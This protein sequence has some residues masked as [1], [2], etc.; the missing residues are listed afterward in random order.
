M[1][2]LCPSWCRSTIGR[3]FFFPT[4]NK[5]EI[6]WTNIYSKI[7]LIHTLN[8]RAYFPF[9]YLSAMWVHRRS[10]SLAVQSHRICVYFQREKSQCLTEQINDTKQTHMTHWPSGKQNKVPRA[11]K[12]QNR[13]KLQRISIW[14]RVYERKNQ[15]NFV[16][17]GKWCEEQV[18]RRGEFCRHCPVVWLVNFYVFCQRSQFPVVFIRLVGS[19]TVTQSKRNNNKIIG[20]L[21]GKTRTFYFGQVLLRGDNDKTSATHTHVF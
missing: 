15:L 9:Y 20:N 11:L 4:T 7:S 19:D 21:Q 12:L 16:Y 1:S 10:S 6:Q 18:H 3:I 13:I 14:N 2:L 17:I 5:S 8:T